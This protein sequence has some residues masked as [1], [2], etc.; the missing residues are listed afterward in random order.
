[1]FVLVDPHGRNSDDLERK[2]SRMEE[3][4]ST[5]NPSRFKL[6][7]VALPQPELGR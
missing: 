2:L 4:S 7:L 5:Q 6:R 1:M 3:Y